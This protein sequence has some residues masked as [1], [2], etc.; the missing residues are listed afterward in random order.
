MIKEYKDLS[1]GFTP[2]CSDFRT[3][4]S[5]KNFS[6]NEFMGNWAN[7]NEYGKHRPYGIMDQSVMNRVQQLRDSMNAPVILTSGYRC[8][9]GNRAVGGKINSRHMHGTAVDIR[10]GCDRKL[11]N[12]LANKAKS[13]GFRHTE[14]GR[15]PDCHLH[16]EN[17]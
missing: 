6:W 12:Q 15:Y 11:F 7:G 1:V 13:L 17:E 10:T 8:P 14:W 4:G 2:S 16:I 9:A 5:T 3:I